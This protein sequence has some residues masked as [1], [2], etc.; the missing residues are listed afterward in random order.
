MAQGREE[1]KERIWHQKQRNRRKKCV[2]RMRR[3]E[4]PCDD[5]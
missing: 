4:G 1:Q 2:T 3:T 5:S